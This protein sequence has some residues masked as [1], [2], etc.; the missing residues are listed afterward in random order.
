MECKRLSAAE[1]DA[2]MHLAIGCDVIDHVKPQLTRLN[3]IKQSASRFGI[4]RWAM[5][6]LMEDVMKTMP[7]E[8]PVNFRNN[9]QMR[10]YIIGVKGVNK[11]RDKEYGLWISFDQF[12][13]LLNACHDHCLM[14]ELNPAE[15]R[16]CPL[17][18]T[19]DATGN[20][21]PDRPDGLCPYYSII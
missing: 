18:K 2:L 11:G 7:T 1:R 17:R 15:Q 8:Q 6:S 16:A 12:N 3:S 14:C 21:I 4:A 5:N 19:L 13:H 10:S 20:D 9:L